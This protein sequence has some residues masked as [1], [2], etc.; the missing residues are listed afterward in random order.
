MSRVRSLARLV[1]SVVTFLIL[2]A[3]R[4]SPVQRIAPRL[5]STSRHAA[6]SSGG[7]TTVP[8]VPVSVR[9]DGVEIELPE[10]SIWPVMLAFGATLFL[11]GVIANI[12][13]VAAGLILVVW[14]IYG[15]IGELKDARAS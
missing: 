5:A 3:R 8:V 14:A 12:A 6:P 10:P 7:Q 11:F 2:V 13:F 9:V 4:P 1:W 15:W